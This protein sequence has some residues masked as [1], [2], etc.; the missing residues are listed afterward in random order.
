MPKVL[1]IFLLY[2]KSDPSNTRGELGKGISD[3]WFKGVEWE[4]R[5]NRLTNRW[6]GWRRGMEWVLL[7]ERSKTEA[8][9]T[10]EVQ[11]T[12]VPAQMEPDL[13]MTYCPN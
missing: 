6:R 9:A 11:L 2:L 4:K 12:H 3:R 1:G 13:L 10:A 7:S 8:G 5:R